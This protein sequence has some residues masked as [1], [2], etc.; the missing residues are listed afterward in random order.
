MNILITG[1]GSGI[2][3]F[4]ATHFVG[5]GHAVWGV[6]RSPQT[7]LPARLQA[8]APSAA[9]SFR[10]GCA[11]LS[12]WAQ[13]AA[14][15]QTVGE[16]WSSLD[17]LI[18]CAG[19]QGPLGPAMQLDPAEW[20]RSVRINLDG[21]FFAIRAFHDLLLRHQAPRAKVFCLSG[22]GSTAPRPNFSP[23]ASAK[24]GV[25]RLVENLAREWN[26][27][28]IDINAIAPG[29]I[30]TRMTEE[31]IQFGAAVVGEKEFQTAD[32]QRR[33]GGASLARLAAMLEYLISSRGDGISG[34][35][36]STPWDPWERLAEHREAL[37]ASDIFT[38]RRIVPGDRGLDWNQ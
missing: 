16:A 9:G 38:L 37:A 13:V 31:V 5:A 7:P 34:R 26:N 24:A 25:V 15:R 8:T 36:I 19:V 11:D 28:S 21:T 12:E 35:L 33:E 14:F 10:S 30:N 22:G 4:L 27:G 6:G 1:S 20:S 17:V 23:Y 2:G 29:A 32:R 3:R 18:C